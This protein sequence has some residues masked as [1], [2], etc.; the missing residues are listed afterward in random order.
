MISDHYV[1][2]FAG[3]KTR[4]ED[5][6]IKAGYASRSNNWVT[7][8][9]HIE[10]RR[11]Q[12]L[13]GTSIEGAGNISG[14]SVGQ[15]FD[16][17]EVIIETYDRKVK[18]YDEVTEDW[19]EAGS[20]TLP[21]SASGEDIA[22]SVY[23]SLAGAMFYLSSKNSSIYKLPVANPDS[24]V[25]QVS[26]D[27]RGKIRIKQSG[28]WLW[29]RKDVSGGF[30]TTGLYR[31]KLDKDELSD[32]T[33][34][35]A[36]ASFTGAVD[37]AN[38]TY[39][40]TLAFKAGG[41]KR[42]CMYVSV[43]ATTGAGTETF[44]DT[45]NGTLVSN[46]GGTGTINYA[47]G[48]VSVTFFNA[49]TSGSVTSDY[50]WEDSTSGGI[51]DFA[52][53][54]TRTAGQGITLR[55]D[56]GGADFQNLFSIGSTEYCFH[57][58]KTWALTISSD[59]LDANN[60][61]YRAKVGI[62]YWRAGYETG[63]GIFYVDATDPSSPAI[64]LLYL[65]GLNSQVLPKSISDDLD[66]S[67]YNFDTACLF[68]W[69]NFICVSC[70]TLNGSANDTVFMYDRLEKTWDQHDLRVSVF[71]KYN[72][73]LIGGDSASRNT[74]KLFSGLTDEDSEIPNEWVSNK[75]R[76]GVEGS[77]IFN[78]FKVKGLIDPDQEYDIEFSYDNGA[79]VNVGHIAGQADYV[80]RST[81]VSIGSH[82]EGSSE[83]GGGG[84][85]IE[86]S[87]YEYEFRVNTPRFEALRVRFIATKVGY[88]SVSEYAMKDIRYKGRR[89]SSQY[90]ST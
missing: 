62:P 83:I 58:F 34:I 71:D 21:A 10:L 27:H 44:R 60:L 70:R 53:S 6:S 17:E 14:L 65:G 73:G 30:D 46:F 75:D 74:F 5:E 33:A 43:S 26:T 8:A 23:H 90:S 40:K 61:I 76:L 9:D 67:G 52:Y 47:T 36:E 35:T 1:K 89:I 19:I 15:R 3:L 81:H 85:G 45:R 88:V 86:A 22:I 16:G 38:K 13:L 39:T 80:D 29:D 51:V 49:P 4:W 79:F 78:I 64:R 82:T 66:L 72:G 77:K 59:D 63:D 41:A 24:I 12:E 31:S 54:A 25:D 20:D 11:G 68:E 57:G 37:S 69:G 56:E 7:R 48:A 50:Y 42:T 32:Y 84:A 28:M 2:N 87:P 18:Y 55:Q